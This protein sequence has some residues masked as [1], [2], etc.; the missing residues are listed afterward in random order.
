MLFRFAK[1]NLSLAA[2]FVKCKV[3][4]VWKKVTTFFK[5]RVSVIL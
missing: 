2:L 3:E 4:T 5:R 1:I